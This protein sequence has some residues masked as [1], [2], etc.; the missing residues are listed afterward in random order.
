MT[1][2]RFIVIGKRF[3]G[4]PQSGNGGYVCGVL[5]GAAGSALTVRLLRP[6]PLDQPLEIREDPEK[7]QIVLMNG[8][9]AVASGR[10][11]TCELEVPEPPSYAEALA[12]ARG[13]EGFREHAYPGCFVCGPE[14][15]RGDGMRIFASALAGRDLYAAPWL[16]DASLA[17]ADGKILAEFMWA[18]L[19]CPGF[20]ATG[21]AARG[22]LLGEFTA[23]ID[24]RV[25]ANEACV[26]TGWAIG[27]KGRKHYTG[28]AVFDD[29]G[30]LCAR[31]TATWIELK[32]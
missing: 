1:A 29:S 6:P 27:H 8:E 25:H 15:A 24:R 16:P 10:P 2:N 23:R 28:T 12:A 18:A 13:Y 31:A 14:R 3:C 17:G 19:D 32:T 11:G 5:A 20:F 30:E 9:E 26:V 22:P 21:L 7:S 4:P